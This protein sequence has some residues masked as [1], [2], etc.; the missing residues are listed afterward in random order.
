M[1][2][3]TANGGIGGDPINNPSTGGNGASGT[4]NH[5]GSG[6]TGTGG[7][8]NPGNHGLGGSASAGPG[9]GSHTNRTTTPNVG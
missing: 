7:T 1:G 5:G 8:G 4:A 9:G 2:T 3:A 6:A